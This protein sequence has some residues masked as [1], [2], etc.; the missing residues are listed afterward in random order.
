MATTPV[1]LPGESHGQRS[2]VGYSP[3]GP[4]ELDVPEQLSTAQVDVCSKAGLCVMCVLSHFSRVQN[5]VTPW[6]V[7]C[8]AP[9]SMGFSR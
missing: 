6:T 5:F 7:A 9:L 4:T 8:Q 3:W 1:F 2:L